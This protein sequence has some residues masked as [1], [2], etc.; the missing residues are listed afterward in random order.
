MTCAHCRDAGDFFGEGPARRELRRYRKRGPGKTTRLLLDAV[1]ERLPSGGFTVLDVGGGV[2][3]LQHELMDE[4]ARRVVSVDASPAYL[5]AARSEAERR[6]REERLEQRLGDF[7]EVA[8][9]V[10]DADVVTLD[11]VVCCY[12]DMPALVGRSAARARLLYGLVFPR[13]EWWVRLGIAAINVWQ[14]LRRSAFRV[15]VHPTGGLLAEVQRRGLVR[16][17][18]TTTF[19]WQVMLFE[20]RDGGPPG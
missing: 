20:R 4:G 18:G 17:F 8:E 12:P 15:Y 9:D 7:V 10:P 16:V 19:L 13:E 1:R 2:G 5:E 3:V 14:R 6:G 11:R